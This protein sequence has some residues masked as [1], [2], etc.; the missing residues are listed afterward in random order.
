VSELLF[1]CVIVLSGWV[2]GWAGG[3]LMGGEWGG[4]EV[5][6]GGVGLD[7]ICLRFP[8]LTNRV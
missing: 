8:Q 6:V 1:G 4:R 7:V 2:G 5:R 3:P